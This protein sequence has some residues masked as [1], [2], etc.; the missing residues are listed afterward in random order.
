MMLLGVVLHSAA[1]FTV[2]P[3]G[4]GW[5]HQDRQQSLVFDLLVFGIH[6]FRMPVFFVMAGFF[7]GLLYARDGVRGFLINRAR[8]VLLPLTL[9]WVAIVPLVWAGFGYAMVGGG[10]TSPLKALDLVDTHLGVL[11]L[12]HL[13]FLYDLLIFYLAAAAIVPLMARLPVQARDAAKAFF[14]RHAAGVPGLLG[15]TLLST[16]T[17]VPMHVPA[18][19]TSDAFLPPLRILA[20]YGVFF[21][22]G[23][24]LFECR[25][26]VPRFTRGPWLWLV[27]ALLVSALHLMAI[28]APFSSDPRLAHAAAVSCLALAMWLWIYGLTGLFLRYFDAPRDLQRYLS[29]GSYWIYLV[30]LPIVIWTAGLVEPLAIHAV[31][32]F[33]IVAGVTT[34]ISVATYQ[35]FVRSRA[36]GALLN[37]RRAVAAISKA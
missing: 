17:L 11:G 36:L 32:K 6:L 35:R 25:D 37:G 27:A 29:D 30:H 2:T 9:A 20:A 8:R 18:L 33:S 22:F 26:I 15:L 16:A 28:I 31:L 7:A 10:T 34:A 21:L 1:S 19:E 24:V 5:P 13:W 4:G 14:R 23:W 12:A 3:L